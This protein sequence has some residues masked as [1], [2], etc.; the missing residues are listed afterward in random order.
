MRVVITGGAGFVGRKL[1]LELLKRGRIRGLEG[2]DVDIDELVLFDI[3]DPQPPLPKDKRLIMVT[4]DTATTETLRAVIAKGT[5]SVFH[6]A[7]VVSAQAEAEFD[8]GMRVN[9]EGTRAMLE[10][11]RAL[12]AAPRVIFASSIA[13]YGGDLPENVSDDTPL[14][15]QT[16][17]GIQKVCGE[18]LVNDYS[19]KAFID[20]RALR[21]PTI[22][23]RP[24]RPNRAASTF[25]SSIIREPLSGAD[26]I[27]PVSR[28]SFMPL[29]SPRR[30]I[31]A[32]L[33]AHDLSGSAFGFSRSLLLPGLRV[34]VGEMAEAV[35]RAGGEAAY[36]RIRWQPDPVI[37]KIVDGWPRGVAARRTQALGIEGDRSID[38]VVQAFIEDDLPAQK[39]MVAAGH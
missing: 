22:V 21:L 11:C 5:V 38:E 34:T 6:L 16:S 28:E 36:A 19:R 10:A 9:L 26:T 13:V 14:T 35:R 7:A 1:A 15:P 33:K 32:M 29:M 12:P 39:A 2:K 3:A 25:A 24:G 31:Q 18:L 17:Y 8:V 20:G 30:L 27:C 4:G 37:Q 23:V